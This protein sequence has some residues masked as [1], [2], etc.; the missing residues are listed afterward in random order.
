MIPTAP[1]AS[2]VAEIGNQGP[3]D[4]LPGV[5]PADTKELPEN[6]GQLGGGAEPPA[7]DRRGGE[8]E[9]AHQ[10]EPVSHSCRSAAQLPGHQAQV[11]YKVG[12]IG[13]YKPHV[14]GHM[15]RGWIHIR[16]P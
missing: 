2:D 13:G 16:K 5:G 6:G 14:L 15:R 8:G 11:N 12:N 3:D 1:I 10:R 4:R 7:G 9:G